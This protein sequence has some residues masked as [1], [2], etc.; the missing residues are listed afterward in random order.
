MKSGAEACVTS[1][2]GRPVEIA[3]RVED[4]ATGWTASIGWARETIKDTFAP[5]GAGVRQLEDDSLFGRSPNLGG[6][7]KIAGIVKD[8]WADRLLLRRCPQ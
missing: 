5:I 2:V 8:N 3:G 6:A 7:I 4:Q 1:V